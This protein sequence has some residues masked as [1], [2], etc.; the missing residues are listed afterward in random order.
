[1]LGR[2]PGDS[3]GRR[4]RAEPPRRRSWSGARASAPAEE[5]GRREAP[6]TIAGWIHVPDEPV[7]DPSLQGT[8]APAV[9]G[10]G[11]GVRIHAFRKT[12]RSG[13]TLRPSPPAD[14]ARRAHPAGLGRPAMG[15]WDAVF[16][17][18]DVPEDELLPGT[19]EL[20]GQP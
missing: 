18:F 12:I 9:L 16:F 17:Q 1:V 4:R 19:L 20:H 15:A 3:G 6:D 10:M 8:I 13:A 7:A 14:A 5:S 11:F 2:L